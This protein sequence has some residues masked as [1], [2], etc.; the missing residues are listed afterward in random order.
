MTDRWAETF[1]DTEPHRYS[2]SDMIGLCNHTCASRSNIMDCSSYGFSYTTAPRRSQLR[3]L[4]NMQS[5]HT[6]THTHKE[7]NIE[8][9]KQI[10]VT[11]LSAENQIRFGSR[12]ADM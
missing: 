5:S 1:M 11:S 12:T 2:A 10:K 3:H 9:M 4:F 7:K 8:I 6:H